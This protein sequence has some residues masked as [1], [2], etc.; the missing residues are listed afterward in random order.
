M[1]YDCP[2][3]ISYL[4]KDGET[5][6]LVPLNDE[7]TFVERVCALIENEELRRTMGDAALKESEKY[8][9]DNIIQRWMMLFQ[10]TLAKKRGK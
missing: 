6:Y 9:M 5:G 4:V 8:K 1:V 7:D 3:G 10:E 2:G